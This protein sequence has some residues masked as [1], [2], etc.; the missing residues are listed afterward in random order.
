M[1]HRMEAGLRKYV[2]DNITII[3]YAAYSA[4]VIVKNDELEFEESIFGM[5]DI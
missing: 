5:W 4:K 1:Q 3:N 2:D